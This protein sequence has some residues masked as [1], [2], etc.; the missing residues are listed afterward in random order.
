MAIKVGLHINEE[1]TKYMALNRR[2][3]PLCQFIKIDN[4]EF[5]R[6]EQ[7]KYLGTILNKK[8][9][10]AIESAARIQAGNK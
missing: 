9:N 4:F 5:K 10:V 6:V 3:T 1:K 2:D 8:N 7:Y